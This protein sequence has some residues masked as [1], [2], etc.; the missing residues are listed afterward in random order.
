[1]NLEH[2]YTAVELVRAD[3]TRDRHRHATFMRTYPV[4]LATARA[5][6][7]DATA[8]FLRAASLAYTW[9]PQRLRLEP[10]HLSAAVEAFETALA[11][12][13]DTAAAIAHEGIDAIA[14]CLSSVAGASRVLHLANPGLYPMWDE[15]I[16]TF[17]LNEEPTPYHMGQ[18]RH[19]VDF[20][21]GI[22]ALSGH[23]LF[24]T[25][26]HDYC[27]AYQGRLQRLRIPPYPLT[28]PRVVES[29]IRELVTD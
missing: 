24:L 22:R 15:E 13:T 14:A 7:P 4:L 20:I 26:H 19:Y 29:A 12:S 17:R 9:V 5:P 8:A 28:E 21:E 16:E 11:L 3:C 23:P 10:G 25:F 18:T 2:L 1:M 6:A 27:T